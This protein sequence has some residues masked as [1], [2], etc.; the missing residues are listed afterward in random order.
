MYEITIKTTTQ[1]NINKIDKIINHCVNNFFNGE[2]IFNHITIN[3][4]SRNHIVKMINKNIRARY[5]VIFKIKDEEDY[6]YLLM[7]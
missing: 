5:D 3:E 1:E 2:I 7:L 6:T 4:I